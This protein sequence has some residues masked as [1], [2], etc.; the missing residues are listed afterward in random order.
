MT[1]EFE[2]NS[3]E[4]CKLPYRVD[5]IRSAV[6]AMSRRLADEPHS[7]RVVDDSS[8]WYSI[9]R[10]LLS[11]QVRYEVAQKACDRLYV[12]G[13]YS[14][15]S[16]SIIDNPGRL[17]AKIESTLTTASP[18]IRFGHTRARQLVQAFSHFHRNKI[19]L[20]SVLEAQNSETGR[21]DFLVENIPGVG[22]KQGSMVLR[23]TAWATH[24]AIID[25]HIINYM[26][27]IHLLK[28]YS[29]LPKT[30]ARYRHYEKQFVDHAATIGE[31]VA[32]LDQA[33]WWVM[34]EI[35]RRGEKWT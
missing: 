8:L 1:K 7:A 35:R 13:L 29:E 28:P 11:S 24:L 19:S 2:K 30:A 26:S 34:R 10:S 14:P 32:R 27:S 15:S 4:R 5:Q 22:M 23:D 25:T 21:R 18:R 16:L 17:R 9:T 6:S 31:P 33:A 20:V 3:K 12:S